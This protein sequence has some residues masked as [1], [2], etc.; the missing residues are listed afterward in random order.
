MLR[1]AEKN[2]EFVGTVF[3]DQNHTS[4]YQNKVGYFRGID[5][6]TACGE[7]NPCSDIRLPNDSIDF[8]CSY[9][10]SSNLYSLNFFPVDSFG[11][12]FLCFVT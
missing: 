3:V 8:R 9:R 1:I 4:I 6:S 10:L 7:S 12:V 2:P 5:F 11:L